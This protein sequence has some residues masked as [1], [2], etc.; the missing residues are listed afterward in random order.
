LGPPDPRKG[1]S[2][3]TRLS[4]GMARLR[5]SCFRTMLSMPGTGPK[6]GT[7]GGMA[8]LNCWESRELTEHGQA[9]RFVEAALV[10]CN[11]RR[12]ADHA[13]RFGNRIEKAGLWSGLGQSRDIGA[14]PIPDGDAGLFPR[15]TALRYDRFW[16]NPC[17][18]T[19]PVTGEVI[20]QHDRAPL[21]RPG[22]QV[23]VIQTGV[24]PADLFDKTR[25]AAQLVLR[26]LSQLPKSPSFRPVRQRPRQSPPER[27]LWRSN[28]SSAKAAILSRGQGQRPT[29]ARLFSSI[30]TITMRSSSVRGMV[31]RN[32]AS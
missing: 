26:H 19:V 22:K 3:A 7:P 23:V 9:E 6:R 8:G 13:I 31:A 27:P 32:R 5:P 17:I 11:Q 4:T 15:K 1:T 25:F 20:A 30:S 18:A 16:Q 29:S 12:R 14:K 2:A 10:F 21:Q 24:H 28:T